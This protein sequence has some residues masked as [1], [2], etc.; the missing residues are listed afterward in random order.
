M[1]TRDNV[2]DNYIA[3]MSLLANHVNNNRSGLM[4]LN[5][6]KSMNAN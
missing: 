1:S 3:V 5:M 6:I 2:S 4:A